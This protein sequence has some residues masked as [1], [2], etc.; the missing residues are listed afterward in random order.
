MYITHIIQGRTRGVCIQGSGVMSVLQCY[1]MG[2]NGHGTNLCGVIMTRMGNLHA[3]GQSNL[4]HLSLLH[5]TPS[6][7]QLWNLKM[8]L[9]TCIMVK[10]KLSMACN[11]KCR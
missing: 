9:Y 7:K 1:N 3:G 5:R 11:L 4:G 8:H 6:F 10:E 2:H